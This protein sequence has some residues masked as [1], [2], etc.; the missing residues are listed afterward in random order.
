MIRFVVLLLSAFAVPFVVH[1]L[2]TLVRG[3]GFRPVPTKM[4][5]RLWLVAVGFVLDALLLA[6]VIGQTP[7]VLGERYVP[8]HLED[9][10]L[11]PGRFEAER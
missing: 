7:R 8:A 9:G 11:I 3:K 6:L 4:R 1:G 2:V 5:G 10:K